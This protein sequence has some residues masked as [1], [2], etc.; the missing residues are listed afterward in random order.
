MVN[1]IIHS[2]RT[3]MTKSWTELTIPEKQYHALKTTAVNLGKPPR[4]IHQRIDSWINKVGFTYTQG[5]LIMCS[6]NFT[7]ILSF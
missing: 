7:H 2:N 3:A 4:H 1:S 6:I 5:K